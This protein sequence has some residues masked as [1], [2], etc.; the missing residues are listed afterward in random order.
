MLALLAVLVVVGDLFAGNASEE[1]RFRDAASTTALGLA[2]VFIVVMLQGGFLINRLVDPADAVGSG[3]GGTAI[4]LLRNLQSVNQPGNNILL[5]GALLVDPLL[6]IGRLIFIGSA[7]I[8]ALLAQDYAHADNPA[9]FFG[10]LVFATIGMDFM[11][12][13]GELI[14]L[15]LSLELASVSL[16]IMAGYFKREAKSSEAGIKYYIF[17]ALSSGILLYGLSLLYGYTASSGA[18]NPTSFSTIVLVMTRNGLS[19]ILLLSLIFIIAGMG[20]KLAVVPFH[21]WS[22]DVYQGAPTPV[23]AFLS[24]A[25]KTAGFLMLAR[26]MIMAFKPLAGSAAV[27]GSFGGWASILA[28][29]AALTMTLGNLAA[30]TQSN[31]KRMLAYSSI[32]HAGFLLIGLTAVYSKGTGNFSDFGMTSLIYYLIAYTVTNLGAFG[33]LAAVSRVVGGDDLS[34]MYGLHR[35]NQPLAAVFVFFILSLA[36]IPPLSGFWAKFFVFQAG[37]ESGAT[38]LVILALFNT[39]ISLY[40]YLRLLKAMFFTEPLDDRKI[41]VPGGMNFSLIVT[42]LLVLALGLAPQVFLP[43]IGT[44][45]HLAGTTTAGTS[46]GAA[47]PGAPA[48]VDPGDPNDQPAP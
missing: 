10:L 16:Y 21:S 22:P 4:R 38:W 11:A 17:G 32:A 28:I 1:Q 42:A 31:V 8:T 35:R 44:T 9:E 26:I 39:I 2:L 37:W 41:S 18:A 46:G 6:M 29:I 36:G 24:T 34:D 43:A 13:A 7:F 45:T 3:I 48:S 27:E 30:I 23:T 40:Y 5:N 25:S 20:Y 33:A 15:Y 14:T 47:Q 19:P 12:G